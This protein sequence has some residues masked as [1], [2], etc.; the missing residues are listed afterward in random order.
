MSTEDFPTLAESMLIDPKEGGSTS[1]TG[2]KA[3]LRD[4]EGG[5]PKKPEAQRPKVRAPSASVPLFVREHNRRQRDAC[6][7]AANEILHAS[8]LTTPPLP[9]HACSQP[10][11]PPKASY[12]SKAARPLEDSLEWAAK[13]SEQIND[14]AEGEEKVDEDTV[15]NVLHRALLVRSITTEEPCRCC[16]YAREDLQ[17]FGRCSKASNIFREF[18]SLTNE[19]KIPDNSWDRFSLFALL[20]QGKLKDVWVD[21]HLLLWKQLIA[22]LVRVELEG[23]KFSVEKV[24]APAW[25]RLKTKILALR[26]RV[27]ETLRRAAS[28]GEE[29]PD[30]SNR[31][32]WVD[33]LASF[34]KEGI[35]KW[36][37]DLVSKLEKLCKKPKPP[38]PRR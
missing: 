35:F 2:T 20:P 32:R 17:H 4:R 19:K 23:E 29:P 27:G 24:W 31:T 16:G 10:S 36:N 18:H 21:L 5:T 37:D 15:K 22:V 7:F 30:V 28:R 13:D 14:P 6:C 8:M 1:V 38:G 9:V 25:T 33:P 26:H 34:D 11:E 12:K 3:H